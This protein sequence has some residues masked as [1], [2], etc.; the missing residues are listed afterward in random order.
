M[1]SR[2]H[3]PVTIKVED[4]PAAALHRCLPSVDLIAKL[5]ALYALPRAIRDSTRRASRVDQPC[6]R[7]M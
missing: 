1:Q 6:E 2:G 5:F 7:R 4:V 3:K